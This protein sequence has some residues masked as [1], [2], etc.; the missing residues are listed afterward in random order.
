[1]SSPQTQKP[2]AKQAKKLSASRVTP[3]GCCSGRPLGR[4]FFW[5]WLFL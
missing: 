2:V 4:F 1:M 3:Q 5:V